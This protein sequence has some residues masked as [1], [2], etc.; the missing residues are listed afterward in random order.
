MSGDIQIL[1]LSLVIAMFMITG[2]VSA[3]NVLIPASQVAGGTDDL[4]QYDDGTA[5]WVSWGDPHRGVWFD[6]D[7]FFTD[8]VGFECEYTEYWFYHL[9]TFPWDTSDFYA[10]LWS[11]DSAGTVSL[12]DC[13]VVTA[14][15]LTAVYAPHD[16][17]IV[18]GIDFWVMVNTELSA[19]GCPSMV[20]DNENSGHSFS[21][22]NPAVGD[23]L[24]RMGGSEQA[25]IE[26]MT[27]GLVKS[28]F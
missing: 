24:I 3:E 23:Y 21:G 22:S 16:P 11:G 8:P 27:W 14:A 15:H 7:D 18:T 6:L 10:E 26:A 20:M 13:Q 19:Q 5:V 12:L 9:S 1:I 2:E 17:P 4:L 25:V 28:S